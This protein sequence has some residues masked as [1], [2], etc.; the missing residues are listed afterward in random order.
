[1][2]PE[3][4]AASLARYG[5]NFF[6]SAK[7]QDKIQID[8]PSLGYIMYLGRVAKLYTNQMKSPYYHLPAHPQ[9]NPAALLPNA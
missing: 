7:F 4:D 6:L 3:S 5:Q 8:I 1:M 9:V 2:S